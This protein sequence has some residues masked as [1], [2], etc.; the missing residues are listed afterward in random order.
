MGEGYRIVLIFL[1][2]YHILVVCD[3][4]DQSKELWG[5]GELLHSSSLVKTPLVSIVGVQQSS[6]SSTAFF[7]FESISFHTVESREVQNL[8]SVI[9]HKPKVQRILFHVEI[10]CQS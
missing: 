1:F 9:L 5:C 10:V 4:L 8:Y 7:A 6:S 3:N 2:E